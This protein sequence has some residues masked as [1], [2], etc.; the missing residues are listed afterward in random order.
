MSFKR[1]CKTRAYLASKALPC[2]NLV[3]SI[4][5]SRGVGAGEGKNT[6][7]SSTTSNSFGRERER[8]SKITHVNNAMNSGVRAS[9]NLS[10][11]NLISVDA[12]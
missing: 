10:T 5:V 11:Q 1:P 7:P 12:Y 3:T 9:T 2:F 6:S 8:S 4:I